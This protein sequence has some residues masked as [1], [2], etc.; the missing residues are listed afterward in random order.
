MKELPID[1]Y[2]SLRRSREH[3]SSHQYYDVEFKSSIVVTA[4]EVQRTIDFLLEIGADD[5]AAQL[6]EQLKRDVEKLVRGER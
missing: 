1:R 4:A 3:W 5:L 2:I 6:A